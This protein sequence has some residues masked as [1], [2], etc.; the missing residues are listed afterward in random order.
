MDLP[1]DTVLAARKAQVQK[2]RKLY[3]EELSATPLSDIEYR[4]LKLIASAPARA[5]RRYMPAA[6]LYRALRSTFE[7]QP[8]D[9]ALFSLE[10][11]G[12]IRIAHT[13]Q[14]HAIPHCSVQLTPDVVSRLYR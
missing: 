13:A 1:T 11:R 2:D 14:Y 10:W 7:E 5:G 9:S 8:I 4:I 12:L 6:T 3:A